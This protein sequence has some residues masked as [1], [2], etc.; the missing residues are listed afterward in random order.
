MKE[1]RDGTRYMANNIVVL[2]DCH[3]VFVVFFLSSAC[4]DN[5][6]PVN[7]AQIS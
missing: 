2:Q 1:A 6:S 7:G 5:C 3:S 4:K